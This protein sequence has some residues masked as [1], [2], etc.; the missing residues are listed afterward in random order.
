[1]NPA[2]WD[3]RTVVVWNMITKATKYNQPT[4]YLYLDEKRKAGIVKLIRKQIAKFEL[5]KEEHGY[6]IA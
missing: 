1:M 3:H 4:Q 2:L 5:S 6:A